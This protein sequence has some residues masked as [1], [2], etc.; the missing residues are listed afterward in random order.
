MTERTSASRPTSDYSCHVIPDQQ[1]I[2]SAT[3]SSA[4]DSSLLA[5]EKQFNIISEE[6]LVVERSRH[7]RKRCQSPAA[8]PRSTFDSR[9]GEHT[10]DEL[11]TQQIESV[12][13]RL[14]PIEWAIMQTPASTI[15]GL[16][17]KARHAAYVMSQYW[18]TPLDRIDWDARAIRQLIEAVC[19]LA[20][21]PLSFRDLRGKE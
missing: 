20:R 5:L 18:E 9:V 3:T 4:E 7:D 15:A 13:T 21:T 17:V 12:L 2:G 16:G 1:S 11:V 19:D 8:Q 6:L 10:C 14:Y